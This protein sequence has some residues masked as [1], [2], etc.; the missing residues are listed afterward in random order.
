MYDDR[1]FTANWISGL[2]IAMYNTNPRPDRNNA[3]CSLSNVFDSITNQHCKLPMLHGMG[4]LSCV[5][6]SPSSL[7][8]ALEHTPYSSTQRQTSKRA[9]PTSGPHRRAISSPA[10]L[11]SW[12]PSTWHLINFGQPPGS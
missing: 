7:K 2:S 5:L 10:S 9:G 8:P 6:R 3:A 12:P 11:D 1:V 4:G